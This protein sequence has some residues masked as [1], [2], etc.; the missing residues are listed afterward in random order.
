MVDQNGGI[1]KALS[2]DPDN[3]LRRAP[4]KRLTCQVG[5]DADRSKPLQKLTPSIRLANGF[6]IGPGGFNP[7]PFVKRTA[8]Q[9]APQ[10]RVN[11]RPSGGNS[12]VI[13]NGPT[14][15]AVRNQRRSGADRH[16]E[17]LT[18]GL[19]NLDGIHRGHCFPYFYDDR[20]FGIC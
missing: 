20:V 2:P 17:T 16:S 3:P 1:S 12:A 19:G 14:I 15:D 6:A 5:Q 8:Q 9:S 4:E 7:I 13:A 11:I 18:C 10:R